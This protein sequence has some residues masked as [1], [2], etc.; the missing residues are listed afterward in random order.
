[1]LADLE[2]FREG[3][4]PGM[5]HI[6]ASMLSNPEGNA[7][8]AVRQKCAR[9][10]PAMRDPSGELEGTL[11]FWGKRNKAPI[12]QSPEEVNGRLHRRYSRQLSII[13]KNGEGI[14]EGDDRISK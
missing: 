10:Q 4:S 2:K 14:I 9:F 5:L 6:D 11:Q 8:T 12:I 3:F 13:E 7:A 1:L